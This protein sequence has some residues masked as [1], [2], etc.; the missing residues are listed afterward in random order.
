MNYADKTDTTY[1]EIKID[2]TLYRVTS[3]YKDEMELEKA[4]E[5]IVIQKLLREND[6]D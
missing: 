3:V 1:H 6:Y 2:K 5:D 4:I